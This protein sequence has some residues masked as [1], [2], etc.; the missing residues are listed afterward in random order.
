MNTGRKRDD[1]VQLEGLRRRFEHW[2]ETHAV[3]SRIADWLWAAAAKVAR[4]EG[5]YRTAR[6][7][8]SIISCLKVGHGGIRRFS[9]AKKGR[10]R[11]LSSCQRPSPQFQVQILLALAN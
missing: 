10:R 4:T 7:C 5:I 9:S 1:T 8:G 6:G 3:H 11:R 2:R